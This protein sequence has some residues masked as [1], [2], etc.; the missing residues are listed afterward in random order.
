[1]SHKIR[2]ASCVVLSVNEHRVIN[3]RYMSR[4]IMMGVKES[5]GGADTQHT[6]HSYPVEHIHQSG[7]HRTG[8]RSDSIGLAQ[9]LFVRQTILQ[10]APGFAQGFVCLLSSW[11]DAHK[12]YLGGGVYPVPGGVIDADAILLPQK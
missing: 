1:M 12:H 3:G 8:K 7:P 6:S 9:C 2:V 4:Q 11:R 5:S 10:T